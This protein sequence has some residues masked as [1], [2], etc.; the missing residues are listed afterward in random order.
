MHTFAEKPKATQQTTSAKPTIPGR[1]HFGQSRKVNS[2]LH[3]QRTIGN[4]AV[5]QILQT[6]AEE[7]RAGPAITSSPRFGHD[8]S[9]ITVHPKSPANVQATLMVALPE[10]LYEQEA[11]YVTEQVM[12]MPAPRPLWQ[13]GSAEHQDREHER[14]QTKRTTR[15]IRPVFRSCRGSLRILKDRISWC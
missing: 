7:L 15:W 8:F 6:N 14:L 10:D 9:Q 5:Q 3:L 12:R 1:A 13:R 4:H 2:I 11:D